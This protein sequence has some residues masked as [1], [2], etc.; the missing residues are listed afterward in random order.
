MIK[1]DEKVKKLYE[2]L[3]SNSNGNRRFNNGDRVNYITVVLRN[4]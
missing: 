2:T 3:R 1:N 4:N